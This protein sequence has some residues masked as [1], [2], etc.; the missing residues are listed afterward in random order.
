[1]HIH[2]LSTFVNKLFFERFARGNARKASIRGLIFKVLQLRS[3]AILP[4]TALAQASK[5]ASDGDAVRPHE[6]EI[7]AW[8]RA[9]DLSLLFRRPVKVTALEEGCR[10]ALLE[11][12]LDFPKLLQTIHNLLTEPAESRLAR[13]AGKS[14]EFHYLPAQ[15]NDQSKQNS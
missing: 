7:S 12:P 3:L 6:Y 5:E 8:H 9:V 2:T 11:K 10:N 15:P 13:M 4:G 1:V 14:A